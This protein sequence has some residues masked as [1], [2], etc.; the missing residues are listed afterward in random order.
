MKY[1][2]ILKCK[3]G[4]LRAKLLKDPMF[5]LIDSIKYSDG[6]YYEIHLDDY[7]QQYFIVYEDDDG[8]QE[9]G[10]GAYATDY[11]NVIDYLHNQKKNKKS[12]RK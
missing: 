5:P 2:Q 7:G 8:K 12:K 3:D 9:V 4:S 10:C 1:K 6:S 11:L